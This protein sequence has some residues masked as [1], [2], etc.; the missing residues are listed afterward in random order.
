MIPL[1]QHKYHNVNHTN[2]RPSVL[3]PV[4]STIAHDGRVQRSA[5]TISKNAEVTV[6]ALGDTEGFDGNG[7]ETEIV[8]FPTHMPARLQLLYF[9]TRVVWA[10]LRRR[11]DVIVAHDYYLAFVGCIIAKIVR[12][13]VIYDAHELIIPTP[14]E[15]QSL[16]SRFWYLQEAASIRWMNVVVAANTQRAQ[17]MKEHYNLKVSPTVVRNIPMPN[18]VGRAEGVKSGAIQLSR[19]EPGEKLLVYQG[20]VSESRRLGDFIEAMVLL[21]SWYRMIVIGDGPGFQ[22]LVAQVQELGLTERVELLGRVDRSLLPDILHQCDIGIVT[23]PYVGLNNIYCAPN[24]VFEYA[25]S[26]L[27]MIATSQ[28]PLLELFAAYNIGRTVDLSSRM[29]PAELIARAII[30]LDDDM[31]KV[32]LKLPD[33]VA[34][35]QWSTEAERL[36]HAFDSIVGK[37]SSNTAGYESVIAQ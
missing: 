16:R 13:K 34:A 1:M 36:L 6:V 24:K 22:K 25:Q 30:E 23:Y 7:Y 18:P 3:M 5:G 17:L 20:V 4:Y 11:P 27:P 28:P 9:Y 12:A 21:P 33:F 31:E 10:A 15:R 19:R 26:G 29:N 37:R 8:T 35:H 32:V 2:R 14:G